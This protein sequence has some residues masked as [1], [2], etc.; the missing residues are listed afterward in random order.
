M[1]NSTLLLA[2]TAATAFLATESAAKPGYE[3][4]YGAAQAGKNDCGAKDGSHGCAGMSK[5]DCDPNEW[6]Y[7]PKGS[8][9]KM[10]KQCKAK[11]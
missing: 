11:M 4:C 1:K 8:C 7:V 10:K 3:K 5:K 2:V 9:A 6:K